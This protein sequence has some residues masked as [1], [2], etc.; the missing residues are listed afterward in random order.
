[1]NSF[2]QVF[3]LSCQ[4]NQSFGERIT[5]LFRVGDDD[6]FAMPQDDMSRYANDSG[7]IWNIPQHNG[8]GTNSGVISDSDVA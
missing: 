4:S 8:A 2:S 1:M 7:T 6:A 5:D 3:Y